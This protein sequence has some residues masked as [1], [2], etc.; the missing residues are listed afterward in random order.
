MN[1]LFSAE[2]HVTFR[3]NPEPTV[4]FV[5]VVAPS[6]EDVVKRLP[7]KVMNGYGDMVKKVEF[8]N[9]RLDGKVDYVLNIDRS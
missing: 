2:M 6:A 3:K 5:K 1:L 9:V 7:E 8:F 4:F